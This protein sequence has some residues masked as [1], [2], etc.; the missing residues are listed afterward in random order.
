MRQP[1][2]R[3]LHLGCGEGLSSRWFHPAVVAGEARSRPVFEAG[4]PK[5][6]ARRPRRKS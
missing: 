5:A 1:V 2:H 4:R 6:P 3:H